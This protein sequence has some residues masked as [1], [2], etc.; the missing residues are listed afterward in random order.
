M[1]TVLSFM[2]L[3]WLFFQT[4]NSQP[5]QYPLINAQPVKDVYF[6]LEITDPFRILEQ[7]TLPEIQAWVDAQNQLTRSYLDTIPF[8]SHIQKRLTE[9]WN[10]ARQSAPFKKGKYWYYF[11]NNGLQNQSVMY[12]TTDLNSPGNV[13][14]DPNTFSADGTSSLAQYSFS[15]DG[16][17]LAY[18]ISKGGSDWNEIKIRNT[19]TKQDLPETLYWVKFSGMAWQK[20][21]FYYSRYP[22]PTSGKLISGNLN[23]Q[24]YYHKLQ[25]Q[26]SADVL[27]YEEKENPKRTFSAWTTEDETRLV[28][29]CAQGASSFNALYIKDLTNSKSTIEKLV[30]TFDFEYDVIEKVENQLFVKTNQKAARYKIIAIDLKKPT[31]DNWKTIIPELPEGVMMDAWI[32]GEDYLV[33]KI[34]KDAAEFLRIYN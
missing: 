34:Q 31:P 23:Q 28:I 16:K 27:V 11:A 18:A 4:G 24:V 14:L 8:R 21:G 1:K 9:L 15:Q 26:Q 3:V 5:F 32:L 19:E 13:I 29:S 30:P 6:G 7:D 10:F 2:V 20:D 22:E 33:V 25:T 12:Q 17:Y